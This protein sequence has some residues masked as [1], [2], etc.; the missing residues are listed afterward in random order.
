MD[1]APGAC[2]HFAN[3]PDQFVTFREK[4][5]AQDNLVWMQRK[6]NQAKGG[7]IGKGTGLGKGTS[8]KTA[9]G[10]NLTVR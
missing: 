2:A 9:V 10:S 1:N 3:N 5:N 6:V 8:I 7:V 4:I